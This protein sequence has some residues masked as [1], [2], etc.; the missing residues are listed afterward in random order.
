MKYVFRRAILGV[1]IVP[2]IAVAWLLFYALL[3]GLGAR[4]TS[5]AE[6]V[7]AVGLFIGLIVEV[8]FVVD[9]LVKVVKR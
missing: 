9:G 8:W 6:E 3:V 1:A 4:Q 2:L 5:S 7:F